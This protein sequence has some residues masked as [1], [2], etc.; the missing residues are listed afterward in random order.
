MHQVN[1]LKPRHIC[2]H[3]ADGIFK[4]I[5]LNENLWF[6]LKVLLEFVSKVRIKRIPTLIQIMA[7]HW[8]GEKPLS[9]P[10]MYLLTHIW[11]TQPHITD[12]NCPKS[13][14]QLPI[15]LWYFMYLFNY[16]TL[17]EHLC[18]EV[19]YVMKLVSIITV[20][21]SFLAISL[22]HWGRDEIDAILQTTSSSAFSWMK[23]F[24][25][26]SKVHWSLF[27]RVELTIFQHWFR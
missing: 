1:T 26:L 20:V 24:E 25:F 15:W 7:R 22:T 6:L 10:M 27:L 19:I 2:R 11:V 17:T 3:F 12:Y 23:M 8:P 14:E 13:Y 4:C 21:M 5:F 18:Y 16:A 9:G